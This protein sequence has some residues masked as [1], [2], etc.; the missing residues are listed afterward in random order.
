MG[1]MGRVGQ[2]L[3]GLLFSTRKGTLSANHMIVL[4]LH[5]MVYSWNFFDPSKGILNCTVIASKGG[6]STVLD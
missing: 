5:M 2:G 3:S 1:C 4:L 6:A